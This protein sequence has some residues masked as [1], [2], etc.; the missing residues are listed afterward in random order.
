MNSNGMIRSQFTDAQLYTVMF[1]ASHKGAYVGLIRG[2]FSQTIE[3]FF[4]EASAAFRFP[5]Y[6]GWN[7]AAFDECM[8][9]LEWL[10]FNGLLFVIDHAEML[11]RREKERNTAIILLEKHLKAAAEDWQTRSI[12]FACFMNN[13]DDN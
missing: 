7:W 3:D 8:T 10:R 13:A 4:R 5:Y 9:D 12:S 2:E 11:F 1:Q 6:F